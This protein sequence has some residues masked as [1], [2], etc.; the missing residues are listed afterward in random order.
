VKRANILILDDNKSILNALDILLSCEYEKVTCISNPN[1]L[2]QE[3]SK[4]NYHVVLLDMNFKSGV[5][6][7]NEGL[8]Y[9]K[10][11]KADYP[12]ISVIMITAYGDIE[13]AVSALKQGAS[14]FVLKPWDNG[15]LKATLNS[16]VE[17]SISKQRI[18]KLEEKSQD[19]SLAPVRPG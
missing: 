7:G 10:E 8:Y 13:L 12:H 16:G 17:I 5:N 1:H 18:Q 3:L 11:I 4:C 2:K 19:R 14:D 15:K 6:N 9:L